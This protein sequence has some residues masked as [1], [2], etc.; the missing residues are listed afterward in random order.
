[1]VNEVVELGDAAV[2]C[3]EFKK[4]VQTLKKVAEIQQDKGPN[5]LT[6][7]TASEHDIIEERRS[8]MQAISGLVPN[9]DDLIQSIQVLIFKFLEPCCYYFI[10]SSFFTRTVMSKF[11]I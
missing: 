2:T 7:H 8:Q 5:L 10:I 3:E 1:M 6:I 11:E 4:T 9:H